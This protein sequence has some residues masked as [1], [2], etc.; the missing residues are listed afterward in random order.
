MQVVYILH[1]RQRQ[2]QS[3]ASI[4]LDL[5]PEL[6]NLL[7]SELNQASDSGKTATDRPHET[8]A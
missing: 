5:K 3:R 8:V 7:H 6:D 4:E 2:Q 1:R